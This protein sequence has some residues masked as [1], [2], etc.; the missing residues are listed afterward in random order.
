MAESEHHQELIRSM[1]DTRH[2]RYTANSAKV[3]QL[4]HCAYYSHIHVEMY[5]VRTL[6]YKIYDNLLP[7]LCN[8]QIKMFLK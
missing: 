4:I 3:C 7:I 8:L 2:G 6:T 1:E 5:N